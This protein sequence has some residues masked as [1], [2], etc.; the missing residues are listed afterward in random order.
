MDTKETKE[1]IVWP[2]NGGPIEIIDLEISENNTEIQNYR[3]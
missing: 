2:K 3:P 1:Q